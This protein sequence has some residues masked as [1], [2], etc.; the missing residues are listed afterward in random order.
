MSRC[1]VACCFCVGVFLFAATSQAAIISGTLNTAPSLA[2]DL[3]ASGQLDWAYWDRNGT[4]LPSG[5]LPPTNSKLSASLISDL[6][7]IGGSGFRGSGGTTVRG[8]YSYADGTAPT[9]GTLSTSH[10]VF[11]GVIGSAG[12]NR[13]LS[14]SIDLPTL[15]TY[16]ISL[17]VGGFAATGSLTAKLPGATDYTSSVIY[18]SDATGGKQLSLYTFTV[19]PDAAGDDFLV[20]YLQNTMT[21]TANGHAYVAAVA[22]SPVAVP[23]PATLA[24]LG[25]TS[26]IAGSMLLRRR[27]SASRC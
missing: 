12:V 9:S 24:G 17:W 10:G 2:I 8:N 11:P 25:I 26:L 20:N 19:T 14:L 1:Y 5:T 3:T 27:R 23:E 18:T 21:D 4:V 6:S 15:Q 7:D 16:Q 22:I 13:G